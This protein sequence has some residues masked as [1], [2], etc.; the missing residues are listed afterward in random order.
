MPFVHRPTRRLILVLLAFAALVVCAPSASAQDDG[1]EEPAAEESAESI[2]GRLQDVDREPVEGVTLTVTAE[3]GSEIGTATSDD[4]GE[5]RVPLPGPGVYTVTIDPETLPEGVELRDAERTS[6]SPEVRAGQDRTV[7]FALGD[8]TDARAENRPSRTSRLLNLAAEGVKFG[9]MIAL[10]ALGLSMVFGVTNLVNFAH[11]E[12]LAFGALVAW[13]L[14]DSLGIPLLLAALVAVALA[15][16][17]GVGFETAVF[18]PVRR[19][20]SGDIAAMVI[21]IGLALVV[22]YVYLILFGGE[23]RSYSDYRLQQTVDLGPLSL[24]PKS[25]ATIV[26]GLL[27]LTAFGWAL[28][29]T[30]IGTAMRAVSVNKDLAESSGIDVRRVVLATWLVGAALAGLSG[31]MFGLAES[32]RWDMGNDVLLLIFAAVVL[33]GLGT[34]YGAMVGGL[35]VGL[36]TQLSTYWFAPD[37]KLMFALV[38]LIVILVARP[39]GILGVKE[40]FG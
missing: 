5:W 26:V 36:V 34:A 3:D 6:L 31:V 24:T 21:S 23:P 12:L 25:W 29:S 33:G 27:V 4:A 28:R 20:K 39:Q 18:G 15:G 35:V 37:L 9:V 22:R 32:V 11:G 10:A 30:R 16:M 1:G 2:G 19:R 38:V 13:W 17:M 14:E 7:L 40:R 8:G